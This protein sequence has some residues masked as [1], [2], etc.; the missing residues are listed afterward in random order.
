[1]N[2]LEGLIRAALIV[3]VPHGLRTLGTA[4]LLNHLRRRHRET[5][6]N[7]IGTIT[8]IYANA[9]LAAYQ[10]I[11]VETSLRVL[12][13]NHRARPV[14]ADLTPTVVQRLIDVC[15][16]KRHFQNALHTV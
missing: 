12:H 10:R 13:D 6:V 2:A 11:A 7:R 8:G 4:I 9:V 1:M 3:R 5:T 16:F 14:D 15:A